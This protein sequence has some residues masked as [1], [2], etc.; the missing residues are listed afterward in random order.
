M[1]NALGCGEKRYDPSKYSDPDQFKLEELFR[2][3]AKMGRSGRNY[4]DEIGMT[5]YFSEHPSWG[6]K[7]Y[8][9]MSQ[10]NPPKFYLD[11]KTWLECCKYFSITFFFLN[12]FSFEKYS[13]K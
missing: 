2:R 1:G 7:M 8:S 6:K 10:H 3:I 12:K 11:L 5:N 4:I 9:W 13:K